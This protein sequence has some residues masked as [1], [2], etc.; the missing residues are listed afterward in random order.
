[1]FRRRSI[2]G[3]RE[4]MRHGEVPAYCPDTGDII[5]LD[6]LQAIANEQ[7]GRRPALVLSPLAFN[8]LTGRCIACPI[9]RR[10]RDWS[11]HVAIPDSIKISGVVQTDQL[12]SVSW[13]QRGSHFICKTSA[14]LLAEVRARLKPLLSL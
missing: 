7:A 13:E 14:G 8:E 1:M 4:A 9:T 5:W 3:L 11:F 2:G 6:F 10:D 12:R